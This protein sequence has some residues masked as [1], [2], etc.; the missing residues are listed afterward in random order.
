MGGQGDIGMEGVR[1]AA[2][3]ELIIQ[4][5]TVNCEPLPMLQVI[6]ERLVLSLTS[7]LKSFTGSVADVTLTSF[8]YMS[9]SSAMGGLPQHGLLAV[10]Y[11][12]PWDNVL[13]VSLDSKFLYAALELMLGG[14]PSGKVPLAERSFTSI[15]RRMGQRM[16]EV[17]LADL[18]EGFSHIS[19]V[20][21]TIDRIES[22]PQ[23]VS[24]SQPG[25][26]CVR[27]VLDIELDGGGGRITMVIPYGTIEPIRPLLTKV[28]FGEKIGGDGTWR[29]HLTQRIESST[30]TLTAMLHERHVPLAEVLGWKVGDTVELW[31]DDDHE[32]TVTCSGVAM[33]N[34]VI[35]K[36]QNGSAALRITRDLNG[37]DGLKN[38]AVSD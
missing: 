32:A 21:F 37:K 11:A 7:S 14:Q 16:A 9:Y 36:K 35:G 4:M 34:G 33:F 18:A 38:D 1:A 22:N 15:E 12:E 24:A 26:P 29:E 28:F 20:S 13:I 2:L 10:T 27:V 30:V 17:V 3:E 31:I 25:S 5:S 19:E 23:F 6:M 8:E